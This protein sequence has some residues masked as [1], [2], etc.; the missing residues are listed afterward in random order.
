MNSFNW[1]VKKIPLEVIFIACSTTE[2]NNAIGIAAYIFLQILNVIISVISEHIEQKFFDV[3]ES[4]GG[5]F[6]VVADEKQDISQTEQMSL[7]VR[8]ASREK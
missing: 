8:Y 2:A 7:C 5:L 6:T 1:L 3:I 4:E